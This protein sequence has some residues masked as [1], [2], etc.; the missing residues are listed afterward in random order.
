[1]SATIAPRVEIYTELACREHK[2]DYSIGRG[3]P[4]DNGF[5]FESVPVAVNEP[6]DQAHQVVTLQ[7]DAEVPNRCASD[8]EVQAAVATLI[9]A[10]TSTMGILA[11]LTTG[12]WGSFS[13][14]RGRLFVMGISVFGILLTY[15]FKFTL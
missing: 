14:R 2:P 10:M 4:L 15:D 7:D 1:M 6:V 12:F 8:P 11:C 13:D 5:T 3:S 9:A